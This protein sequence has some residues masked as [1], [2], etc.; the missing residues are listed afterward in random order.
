MAT[1]LVAIYRIG[2]QRADLLH[3][4]SQDVSIYQD[5]AETETCFEAQS[6]R[7][8]A[9]ISCWTSRQAATRVA[10]GRNVWELPAGS[11]NDDTL[12]RARKHTAAAI[13]TLVKIAEHGKS[14][15]A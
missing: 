15:M 8:R 11:T 2:D 5:V 1:T 3:V 12:L 9:G 14:E 10:N 7:S 6:A 4:R 13:A